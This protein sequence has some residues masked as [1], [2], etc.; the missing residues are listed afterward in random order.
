MINESLHI[1][2]SE[3]SDYILFHCRKLLSPRNENRQISK[4]GQI[5]DREVISF[6]LW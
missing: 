2:L 5:I 6:P 4:H 1:I 3:I